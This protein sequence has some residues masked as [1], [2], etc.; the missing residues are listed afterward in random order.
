MKCDCGY[1]FSTGEFNKDA[2]RSRKSSNFKKCLITGIIMNISVII[3]IL[4]IF[5]WS[6]GFPYRKRIRDYPIEE[7]IELGNNLFVFFS[8][9][10]L[11]VAGIL[12]L[13]LL[14]GHSL[15]YKL[16]YIA[17]NI[18]SIAAQIFL[19]YHFLIK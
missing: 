8:I 16:M 5:A 18:L 7:Y 17:S 2:Y 9:L 1:D 19:V 4:F 14:K 6:R 3:F 12:N 15:K 10:S 13:L 11:I